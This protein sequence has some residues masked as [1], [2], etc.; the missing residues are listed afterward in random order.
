MQLQCAPKST[1]AHPNPQVKDKRADSSRIAHCERHNLNGRPV[2]QRSK[3]L[4]LQACQDV[5]KRPEN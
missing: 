2:Q 4:L 3:I 1:E 5:K